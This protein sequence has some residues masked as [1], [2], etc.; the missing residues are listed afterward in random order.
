MGTPSEGAGAAP[1]TMLALPTEASSL[2]DAGIGVLG[3]DSAEVKPVLLR[4]HLQAPA[5]CQV[6]V[7]LLVTGPP[8]VG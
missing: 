2:H 4:L 7:P 5:E 3:V 8:I 6:F 1:A